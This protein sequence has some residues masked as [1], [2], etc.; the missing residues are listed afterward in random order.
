MQQP[1]SNCLSLSTLREY[2]CL[3][4]WVASQKANN[5]EPIYHSLDLSFTSNRATNPTKFSL[6]MHVPLSYSII[7]SEVTR[8]SDSAIDFIKSQDHRLKEKIALPAY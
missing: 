6:T 3:A 8:G 1:C 5:E 4:V 2:T 7:S